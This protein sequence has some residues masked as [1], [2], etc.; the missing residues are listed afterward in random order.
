MRIIVNPKLVTPQYT[1]IESVQ[2]NADVYKVDAHGK[3]GTNSGSGTVKLLVPHNEPVILD[4]SYKNED[5][6]EYTITIT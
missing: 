4:A 1:I 5:G 6:R 2:V 3:A